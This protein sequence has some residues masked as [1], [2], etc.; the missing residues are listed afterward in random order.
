[1][2]RFRFKRVTSNPSFHRGGDFRIQPRAPSDPQ[3][4]LSHLDRRART[5]DGISGV[6]KACQGGSGKLLNNSL[7]DFDEFA[8]HCHPDREEPAKLGGFEHELKCRPRFSKHHEIGT[9]PFGSSPCLLPLFPASVLACWFWIPVGHMSVQTCKIEEISCAPAQFVPQV[10]RH[11]NKATGGLV[12][13]PHCVVSIGPWHV[14]VGHVLVTLH[15]IA[16]DA[17]EQKVAPIEPECFIEAF[18]GRMLHCQI[19]G[20]TPLTVAAVAP[21]SSCQVIKGITAGGMG[22][23]CRSAVNWSQFDLSALRASASS[24]RMAPGPGFAE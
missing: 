17:A 13:C 15:G 21:Q 23:R 12:D 2:P 3:S 22:A 8:K 4:A 11:L 18:G 24:F 16:V 6:I 10:F 9:A 1:M 7:S 20:K 5:F 14:L 19:C